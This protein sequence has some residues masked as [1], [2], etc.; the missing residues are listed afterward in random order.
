MSAK[1]KQVDFS[2]K[3]ITKTDD[4]ENKRGSIFT[5][6][7]PDING[8]Y[9]KD[10]IFVLHVTF[11]YDSLVGERRAGAATSGASE[12]FLV[13]RAVYQNNFCTSVEIKDL[14]D[15]ETILR[16]AQE[17]ADSQEKS[18]INEEIFQSS[19]E[20]YLANLKKIDLGLDTIFSKTGFEELEGM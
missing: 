18:L 13:S 17:V 9:T 10:I 15:K 12:E 3:E 5:G 7:S 19:S 2:L 8:N 6:T 1:V 16:L 4:I 11:E 14:P 20:R